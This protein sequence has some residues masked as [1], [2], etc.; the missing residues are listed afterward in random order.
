[1]K[2]EILK[3]IQNNLSEI[4]TCLIYKDYTTIKKIIENELKKEINEYE[5]NE[6][7]TYLKTIN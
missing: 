4:I 2:K 3:S 6:I 1:M 7:I 5:F